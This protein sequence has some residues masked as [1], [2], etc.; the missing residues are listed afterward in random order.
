MLKFKDSFVKDMEKAGIETGIAE[1]PRY[2]FSTG[3]YALNRIIS[4]SFLKGIPQGR[5]VC[6]AGP[7]GSG[8][9]FLTCNAIREA[10][11][12]GAFVVVG[13]SEHALDAEFA[14]KIGVNVD[15]D[16]WLHA[17]LDTI[18]QTQKYVSAFL[19]SYEN[20]YGV[21]DPNAP[22]VLIVIDSL[23]MLMTESEEE[24]FEKGIMK[25]DQGLR[26][27]QIKA[28]L[29]QFVHG[30]KHQNI[31][32]IVTHQ[33]YK[34]QDMMN[35][36]GIWIVNDGVKYS[37][38]QIVLLT[39]LKL[40]GESVSD[41]QGIR[42]KCEGYKTRFTKPFQTVTI[43]V[44]YDTGMDPYNG[45]LEAAIDLGIVEQKGSWYYFKDKKFYAKNFKEVADEVLIKCETMT[46]K[47]INVKINED[48]KED[49]DSSD[50]SSKTKRAE[51]F[52]ANR[53]K[54]TDAENK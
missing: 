37:L 14:S 44:P 1:P 9:T 47:F 45:L 24:N 28:M 25:A 50:Q 13:D 8:K 38:S 31:S 21:G 19:K 27:K 5:I 46:N 22:K 20:E 34:N 32:M 48:E 15:E 43:E 39:K 11:K 53:T 36:E 23:D 3:N 33:V 12:E 17:D 29:R 2:W 41:I 7:S 52:S 10:Q 49:T 35:G 4:G 16:N 6:F 42:M 51:K 26:S 30:I 40:R 54:E 18:P